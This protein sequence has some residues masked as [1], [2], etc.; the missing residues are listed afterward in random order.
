MAGIVARLLP[1]LLR[2]CGILLCAWTLGG[3]AGLQPYEETPRVSLVSIQPLDMQMLEQRFALQLR[4]MNP[5]DVE[6]PVEGLSYA[7]EINQREFAYG[8]SQQAVSIPPYGEALLRV[9][10][11]SNLLNVMRQLQQMDDAP[12]DGGGD[13]LQGEAVAMALQPLR[14][15]LGHELA[16]GLGRPIRPGERRGFACMAELFAFL[17]HE[18][19]GA[20]KDRP[21][22]SAVECKH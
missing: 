1:A 9:E 15:E 18:T 22:E 7:L 11:I 13:L 17:E 20:R 14:G 2:N 19:A 12:E 10:V 5:N 16:Y 4:I 6:I 21:S 8:V 3:C